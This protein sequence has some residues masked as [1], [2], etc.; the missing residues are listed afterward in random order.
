MIEEAG[1]KNDWKRG[2]EGDKLT[3]TNP[4]NLRTM[5]PIDSDIFFGREREMRRIEGMLNGVT[6]SCIFVA[7]MKIAVLRKINSIVGV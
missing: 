6:A 4:Y 7:A 1:L 5:I 2:Q 3:M